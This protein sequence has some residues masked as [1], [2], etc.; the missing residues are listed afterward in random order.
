MMAVSTLAVSPSDYPLAFKDAII[1]FDANRCGPNAAVDNVFSSWRSAC[2]TTD[3]SDAGVNLAGG[4]HDAGD[5]VKF[6]LPQGYAAAVLGWS[7]YEYRDI[8]DSTGNTAKLLSTL[9][10][11]TDY[12]LI[13]HTN[14]TTFY[15]QVGDG[16]IDHSYWG[17]PEVQTGSRP[18]LFCADT[19]HPASDICGMTSSALT[20]MYL[21]YKNIDATYANRCLQAAKE[22]YAMATSN[23]AKG[24]YQSY[25]Q[26][27]SFWDD[28]SWAALWLY[29][30]EGNS[31]YLADIDSYLSH[32]TEFNDSPFNDKWTI[33]WD[34]MYL[35]VFCKMAQVTGIQKYKDAM[36][37][38]LDYW[39]NSLNKTPGGLRVLNYWGVLRYAA[40]ESMIA[41]L[42]YQQTNDQSLLTFAKSQ[43]D[44][45]F[46][47]P[48]GLSYMIGFGS[49]WPQHVHHRGANGYTF[50]NND[51]TKPAQHT[52]TGALVGGPDNND[53]YVDDVN[54]PQYT[55]VALDYNAGLV[56]ALAGAVKYLGGPINTPTPTSRRNTETPTIRVN[57]PTPTPTIGVNTPTPTSRRSLTPTF[58]ATPTPTRRVRTTPTSRGNTPTRR[59]PTVTPT[60]TSTPTPTQRV[61]A[62]ATPTIGNT[63][64]ATPTTRITV[65]PTP[66]GRGGYM[67]AY[68]IQSDWGNGSTVNVTITNNTATG[69]NGWTLAWTFPGNQTITNLWNGTYTQSG[70]SISVKDGGFNA[71]IP[72]SGGTANFGFNLNYSGSNAKPTSFTLNGTLCQTQ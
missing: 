57:S 41:L 6:G 38:N 2:H 10:Y 7:L 3:G 43:I 40:A 65:T 14:A 68:V 35:A 55:E 30:V 44:Y 56:G 20:L 70:A 49:S 22:L 63:A 50:N 36:A 13:S 29:I 8:F 67:V 17:P 61:V 48:S 62:T 28:L 12:F 23:Q 11:F 1:F 58:R 19:S 32:N 69:V 5:H 16:D 72:A 53:V 42:Y 52:L 71:N 51:N 47:N 9:K 24:A 4:F 64:T 33:C 27:T 45:I 66:I 15:Y 25:Y 59:G 37:Y 54:Q 26:S 31:A 21:N 46:T 60:M 39:K 18:T 34:D